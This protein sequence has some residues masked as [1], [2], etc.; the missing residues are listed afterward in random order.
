MLHTTPQ[1]RLALGVVS[2]LLAA[3]AGARWLAAERSPAAWVQTQGPAVDTPLSGADAPPRAAAERE[4]ERERIRSAPLAPGERIDPNRASLEELERLPRVGPALAA[5]IVAHREARGGLRS[6][7]DLDEVPGVGPSLLRS[8][9][10]HL[11]LPPGAA[12]PPPGGG[13]PLDLNR[14]TAAELEALPGVGAALAERIV[15]WRRLHGPFRSVEELERVRGI[16]PALRARLAPRLRVDARQ[17]RGA[18]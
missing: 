10:P 16:G 18:R 5:R 1:E 11:T 3:G 13:A 6:L 2:L 14:A 4:R 17:G 9:A 7:A 15:E 12:E 8:L